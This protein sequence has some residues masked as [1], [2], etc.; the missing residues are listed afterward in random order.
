LTARM[1]RIL[2][3]C[4]TLAAVLTSSVNCQTTLPSDSNSRPVLLLT[5]DSLTEQGTYPSLQGWV[6]LLQAR[7]THSSDVITRG[8]S[9]F[10]TKWFLKH[11][12]P[13]L[14]HEIS[15]RAYTPPSLITVWLGTN[16]AALA[17]GSNFAMH[18]PID[19]YKNNLIKI[20]DRFR[21]AAPDAEILLITPPH[22]N[23]GARIEFAANRADAK[24]GLVDR[25]NAAVGYYSRAC[26]EVANSLK[27]PVLD[28]YTYFNAI[29]ETT[30]NSMLV[31]GIHFNAMGN[32]AVDQQLRNKLNNEFPTLISAL[33]KRQI[34]AVSKYQAEDPWKADNTSTR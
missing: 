31:D 15:T 27:V 3:V 26:V 7:Y 5:G 12:I 14:E 20:V 23:D 4:F 17:N 34:P 11:V 24:R 16:D 29:N 8:L 21:N 18:V 9:G 33:D 1:P 25:S 30:R 10:N 28:L 22:I 19:E 32:K 6:A 13:V 2:V